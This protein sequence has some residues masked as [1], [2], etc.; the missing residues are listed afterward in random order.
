MVSGDN[1]PIVEAGPKT[2][3]MRR[4]LFSTDVG[5]K[6]IDDVLLPRVRSMD[7]VLTYQMVP[8]K[9]RAKN[10]GYNEYFLD[11]EKIAI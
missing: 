8:Y 6:C 3:A 11:F 5:N 1:P 4:I 9:E 7:K 2:V 10:I